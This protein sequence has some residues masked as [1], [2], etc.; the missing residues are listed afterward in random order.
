VKDKHS[1][2]NAKFDKIEKG[3]FSFVRQFRWTLEAESIDGSDS[4]SEQFQKKIRL[5]LHNKFLHIESYETTIEEGGAHKWLDAVAADPAKKRWMIFTTYDGSGTPIY[6][7]QFNNLKIVSREVSFDYESSDTANHKFVISFDTFTREFLFKPSKAA[8]WKVNFSLQNSYNVKI[9]NRPSLTIEEIESR[10]EDG[11]KITLVP[12][13][14]KWEDLHLI[15]DRK[16]LNSFIQSL[17]N[18]I[19]DK[20]TL[21]LYI[22]DDKNPKELWVIT[23]Y[24][25]ISFNATDNECDIKIK[26]SNVKLVT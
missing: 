1:K 21:G 5:D 19:F 15:I 18:D 12:G 23:G 7:Y 2:Q 24:S 22:E 6:R 25:L 16:Y 13:R 3:E 11:K 17:T 8:C 10:S 9:L 26:F 4:L 14:A 20:M